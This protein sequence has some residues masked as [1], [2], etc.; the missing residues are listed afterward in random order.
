MGV[1]HTVSRAGLAARAAVMAAL[2]LAIWP[3]AMRAAA[4]P[5][6]RVGQVVTVKV[7]V[8]AID[9]KDRTIEVQGPKG[10]KWV[11][12]VDERVKRLPE[13]KV[14]DH[15]VIH[16]IEA[17][18]LDIKKSGTAK[19]GLVKTQE[20]HRAASS[21]SPAGIMVERTTANVKVLL[22]NK[23]DNS[24][25]FQNTQGHTEWIKVKDPKLKPYVKKLKVGDIVSIT[26]DEA[27]A[28]S[29]EPA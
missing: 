26:Y 14:G 23:G 16:Y 4:A 29:V 5:M 10:N 13:L 25:T 18:A 2:L 19:V 11:L 8:L 12:E 7:K 6:Q 24:V 27:V 15:I 17:V 9:L 21:E 22:V 28:L 20:I 1:E 3:G